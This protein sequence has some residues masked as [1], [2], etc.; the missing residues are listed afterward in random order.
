MQLKRTLIAIRGISDHVIHVFLFILI[1]VVHRSLKNPMYYLMEIFLL[2]IL[3]PPLS[4]NIHI[5]VR[6]FRLY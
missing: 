2:E 3:S 4:L 5:F 1:N 6:V